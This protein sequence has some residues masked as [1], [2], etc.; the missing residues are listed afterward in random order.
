MIRVERAVPAADVGDGRAGLELRLRAVQRRDPGL[1]QVGLVA[2]AE[3]A[4]GALEEPGVVLAP[5]MPAAGRE[6]PRRS[7]ARP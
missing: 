1:D 6:A 7:A 4:L 2:G 5:G 3:E